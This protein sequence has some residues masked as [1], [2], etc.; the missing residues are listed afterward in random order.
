VASC[1]VYKSHSLLDSVVAL[2][3]VLPLFW[4]FEE[5]DMAI[6]VEYWSARGSRV[7]L[8]AMSIAVLL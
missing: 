3:F 2:L 1:S 7:S 8:Q 6:A 5:V 4:L